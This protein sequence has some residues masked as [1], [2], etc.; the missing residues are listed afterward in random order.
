MTS[1]DVVRVV[2]N[3]SES[4]LN[5]SAAATRASSTSTI[6]ASTTSS[7]DPAASPASACPAAAQKLQE[8][9]ASQVSTYVDSLFAEGSTYHDI[10]MIWGARMLSPTGIFASENA[11][12]G[13]VPTSRHII[14][15]TDGET[16]PADIV[17]GSYGIEPIDGRRWSQGSAQSLTQVVEGRTTVACEEAK[18]VTSQSG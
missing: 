8:M 1:V 17:Y 6:S 10:G 3:Q 2:E 13:A 4:R 16:A 15:L 7:S 5:S 11:D 9:N 14:F 12:V 18:S